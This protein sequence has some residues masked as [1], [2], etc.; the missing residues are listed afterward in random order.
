MSDPNAWMDQAACRGADDRLFFPE[1]RGVSNTAAALNICRAC[2][3]SVPCLEHALN[4]PEQFGVWGG[5]TEEQRHTMRRARARKR[6][7]CGTERGYAAH[8]RNN[9]KACPACIIGKTEARHARYG[10]P[11]KRGPKPQWQAANA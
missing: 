2:P 6:P 10:P 4:R 7:P 11:R 3:V 5:T 9:E 8:L 1:I